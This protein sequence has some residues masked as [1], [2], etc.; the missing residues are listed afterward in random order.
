[1]LSSSIVLLVLTELL[2]TWDFDVVVAWVIGWVG[3]VI[4]KFLKLPYYYSGCCLMLLFDAVVGCCLLFDVVCCCREN[5]FLFAAVTGVCVTRLI[6]MCVDGRG[7]CPSVDKDKPALDL[8]RVRL[9][10]LLFLLQ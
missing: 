4:L 8:K 2:V 10:K 1:M 7:S 6:S 9:S 5:S 3:V